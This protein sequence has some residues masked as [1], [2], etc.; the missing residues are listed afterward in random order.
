METY[1][2]LR[3]IDYLRLAIDNLARESMWFLQAVTCGCIETVEKNDSIEGLFAEQ[4]KRL[5]GIAE[6]LHDYSVR[7]KAKQ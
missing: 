4:R 1:Q 3:Q 2:I 7:T 5:D 6:T